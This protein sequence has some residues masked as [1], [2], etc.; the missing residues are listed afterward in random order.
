M[1]SKKI[2][3]VLSP[4]Y[5]DAVFSC[6]AAMHRWIREGEQVLVVNVCAASPGPEDILSPTAQQFHDKMGGGDILA[7][8]RKEDRLALEILGVDHVALSFKDCIYRGHSATGPWYYQ[9]LA[10]IFGEV[11]AEED[12]LASL[13]RFEL[14]DKILRDADCI[15]YAP[16]AIGRHVDHQV[17]HEAANLLQGVGHPVF[18]YEDFPYA[19]TK[20]P[21]PLDSG[22]TS[23][24]E[25][26]L[27]E[28]SQNQFMEI[29]RAD[30]D[31]KIEAVMAYSSQLPLMFGDMSTVATRFRDFA[32]DEKENRLVERFW[33]LGK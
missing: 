12:G 13:V 5:D 33:D 9:S 15:M 21:H 16:L 28:D 24:L 4:H 6:G 18:Y 1:G 3:L 7:N 10:E 25:M 27:S 23:S 8:R 17:V 2:R 31:A 32:F 14:K 26:L 30:L 22:N 11:H 20:Y 19:D 29:S